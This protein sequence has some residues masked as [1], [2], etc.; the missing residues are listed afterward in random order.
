MQVNKPNNSDVYSVAMAHTSRP[1]PVS[2]ATRRYRI[3]SSRRGAPGGG[4]RA[5]TA[6]DWKNR[7]NQA[8]RIDPGAG[9][10][11][12]STCAGHFTAAAFTVADQHQADR[13][14]FPKFD[15]RI[16]APYVLAW[17][18]PAMAALEAEALR[19]TRHSRPLRH[20]VFVA[21][22]SGRGG[23]RYSARVLRCAK[24]VRRVCA[25]LIFDGSTGRLG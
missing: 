14:R 1:S 20:H 19:A 5:Q 9:A 7:H 2:W 10:L 16:D 3:C 21:E 24:A 17:N 18:E 8:H 15:W 12:C 11:K 13:A 25:L 4:E 6:F 23:D 22:P